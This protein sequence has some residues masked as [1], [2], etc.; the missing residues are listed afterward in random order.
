MPLYT[1]IVPFVIA[2]IAKSK[3]LGKIKSDFAQVA[4]EEITRFWEKVKPI[5]IKEDEKETSAIEL[6]VQNGKLK[7]AEEDIA[8]VARSAMKTN[9]NKT[10]LKKAL[11]D[12]N[13]KFPSEEVAIK[14]VGDY[15]NTV[16]NS[17]V[18]N[19]FNN[20]K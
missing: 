15:N 4:D 5:F 7:E 2:A 17:T 9:E 10:V 3:G 1:K 14:V 12:L 19:S 18:T 8:F 16:I 11:D 20:N 6:K 13:S